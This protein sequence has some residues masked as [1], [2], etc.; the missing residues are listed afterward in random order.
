VQD[1]R[2]RHAAACG[3]V[4]PTVIASEAKQSRRRRRTGLLR[5]YAPRNDGVYSNPICASTARPSSPYGFASVSSIS[6]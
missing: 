2:T 3:G 4:T 1:D 5:R 6:K